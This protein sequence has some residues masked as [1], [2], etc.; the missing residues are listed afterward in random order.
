M[1]PMDSTAADLSRLEK[2]TADNASGVRRLEAQ[3]RTV[4]T[5]ISD[6]KKAIALINQDMQT[7][8]YQLSD[9]VPVAPLES[10][11]IAEVVLECEVNDVI[12]HDSSMILSTPPVH[13]G[14]TSLSESAGE[15]VGQESV[16]NK[17]TDNTV[18]EGN[19]HISRINP[20]DDCSLHEE[21]NELIVP[22]LIVASSHL[23]MTI[24]AVNCEQRGFIYAF[25]ISE[26]DTSMVG[27]FSTKIDQ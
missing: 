19:S 14:V 7:L 17:K 5:E 9:F 21:P 12:L 13:E 10:L 8:L 4:T 22:E 18:C 16:V 1:P 23:Y 2:L 11:R 15:S 6:L 3:A 24:N 27:L 20:S 25:D 26:R